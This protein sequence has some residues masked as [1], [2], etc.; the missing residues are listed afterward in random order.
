MQR[1]LLHTKNSL[2][3]LSIITCMCVATISLD[4]YAQTPFSENSWTY[5]EVDSTRDAWGD[6][7]EPEWLRYFGV[8][9]YDA[10][11]DGYQDIVAG[12]SFYRNPGGDM[13][14]TWQKTDL[15]L[16]VDAVLMLDVDGDAYSDAI[17]QALPDIY[18]LEAEDEQ[19]T[20][21]RATKVG[22]VPATG[23]INSQG[24]TLADVVA[25]GKPEI[26]IAGNGDIYSLEIPADPEKDTWRQQKIGA[27]SSDEGIGTGDIDG[28]GDI[29]I[30]AGRYAEGSE[31]E[32][33]T[34]VVW[35]QNP[36]DGSADWASF[37][38]GS[39]NHAIDR[40]AV[41]D[42]NGDQRADVVVSEERYP[43]LEPDG[44]LF[45]YAC[46]ED[47]TQKDWA[48]HR[49][50]TQY[51]MNNLSVADLDQ[52]GDHDLVTSEHK[53][54]TLSLQAWE[55]DG[56]GQFTQHELDQ[57]KE[58]HLGAQ[59]TD[60]DGDGDLD[61]MSVGWD[62]P[63]FL[64]VWRNDSPSGATPS[65]ATKWKHYS[66]ENG[67]LPVPNPGQQQTSSLAV[68]INQDQAVDFVITE[69]TE[70]P[71][72]V[73]YQKSDSG[74]DRYV[75]EDEALRIEAGSAHHD[76]DGDGD[77]DIVFAGESQSNEVW[78][79]ENPY[80]NFDPDQ[81][82]QRYTIKKSGATKHHDQLFGDFDGDG[83]QEL[84]FWNQQAKAL[85]VAEIPENPKQSEEWERTT[86]YRYH[87]DSQMGQ[88]GQEGYPDWKDV[89]E[90]E[91]LAKIDID[92]DGIED[93]VG[94]GRWFKYDGEGGYL[95]NIIDA[96]Y[97][98]TRSA[99]GQFIEG[100]RPEVLLVVGDGVA[101]MMLYE[102]TDGT[103][104]NHQVID[105]L[106]N[107][108]TID[109][110]DFNDDGHLD[111]FS[112]EMRFG[113]GNPDS[114]VR[115]MLGDGQG[116]FTE[117]VVA[118]GFGVHEGRIVDLDGDGDYDILGKP[119]SWKTPRLDVWLQE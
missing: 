9:A 2:Y 115:I 24:F 32:E 98:F 66:S 48:R 36:G 109:V 100:G 39:S 116:N 1:T 60:L 114:K 56:K 21:W 70:A 33:P 10:T 28:D 77:Q 22:T 84:A 29:D 91:G 54:P 50:V 14:G 78:W 26:L 3:S 80:P 20:T 45:W 57:G 42:L 104:K 64:H 46:P 95:E 74:W 89:N 79:W 96:S 59:L 7:A 92:G 90:H 44:N 105:E 71:S 82:W 52:D 19:G 75:V 34:Q 86:V 118:E 17:G 65:D 112:A 101:P 62:Q 13:T 6:Y 11:G 106:D 40:V 27:A 8:A 55:N 83:Q 113:E 41:T 30:A 108:H 37:P 94:G 73:W 99:V 15:G 61:M 47:P 53:G 18:W 85:F 110:L 103:W 4:S 5:L 88:L 49:V 81:P 93:M 31:H 76:I 102:W 68:D 119:Y 43:G 12:R 111:I 35:W 69:R 67:D 63:E 97:I 58:S 87:T 16:N 107:G 38:I 51:S 23:H 117:T 25:G 72:V